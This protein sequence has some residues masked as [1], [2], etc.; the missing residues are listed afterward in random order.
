[1]NSYM[2]NQ[3]GSFRKI[4][5]AI[6]ERTSIWLSSKVKMHVCFESTLPR[7]TLSALCISADESRFRSRSILSHF[8]L[9]RKL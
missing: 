1:M 4:F 2:D 5:A 8:R 6:S 7:K 3:V 9:M